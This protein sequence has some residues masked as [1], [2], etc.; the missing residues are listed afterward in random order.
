MNSNDRRAKEK[1]RLR[2]RILDVARSLFTER[3]YES[4]KMREIARQ[5]GYTATALYYHF[6]DKESLLRELCHQDFLALS[7]IFKRLGRISD[8]V[9]RIR[10]AGQ[11]YVSFGLKYPQQYRLMFLVPYPEPAPEAIDIEKGNPDQDAYA[12][13]LQAVAEA[14][15]AGRLRAD[16]QDPQL[17]A[18]VLWA[19]VHGL[20]ALHLNKGEER[21]VQ[22]CPASKA[23]DLITA[24]LFSGLLR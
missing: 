16:L 13:I 21:W 6:P 22:W 4:V 19:A 17:V 18:Q 5:I 3:G 24:Q 7:D 15:A 14:M 23:A 11:A 2:K 9:E 1:A 10:K 8:P 12:F 20:V